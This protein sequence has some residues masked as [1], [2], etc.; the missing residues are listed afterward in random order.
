MLGEDQ[1][2]E[3][4][5]GGDKGGIADGGQRNAL[6]SE[7]ACGQ[8]HP[9]IVVEAHAALKH[10]G[11]GRTAYVEQ[12]PHGDNQSGNNHGRKDQCQRKVAYRQG[13]QLGGREAVKE[14]AWQQNII[15]QPFCLRPKG[16]VEKATLAQQIS[17]SDQQDNGD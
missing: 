16:I 7:Q 2:A 6:G 5:D 10:R 8:R 9:D 15:T 14:Q 17:K 11:E 13:I 1:N 3:N 4:V 12:G